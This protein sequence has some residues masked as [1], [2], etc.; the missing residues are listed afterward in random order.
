MRGGT[1]T[2]DCPGPYWDVWG[3]R[4]FHPVVPRQ[5]F[6]EDDV[7]R[8]D[9]SPS[10]ASVGQ[11]ARAAFGAMLQRKESIAD[12]KL[13]KFLTGDRT[14]DLM[15]IWRDRVDTILP[16]DLPFE[17]AQENI[18][19]KAVLEY[20]QRESFLSLEQQQEAKAILGLLD[21]GEGV[22]G[23]DA[24]A[25]PGTDDADDFGG[26]MELEGEQVQEQEQMQEQEE[27]QEQEQEEEMEL[28][29]QQEDVPVAAAEK[30]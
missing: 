17:R 27:E 26:S 24:A 5:V 29:Q 4:T 3:F 1:C 23:G 12:H 11:G 28:E 18:Y 13:T 14:K 8:G 6:L 7:E 22:V 30:E 20:R 19:E 16:N 10:S 9:P 25:T 2:A 21:G 15:G